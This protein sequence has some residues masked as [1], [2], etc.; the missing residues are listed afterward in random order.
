M[1]MS[2]HSSLRK[3][4]KPRT[5]TWSG[6]TPRETRSPIKGENDFISQKERS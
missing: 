6:K 3:T 1:M 2:A 5:G 4:E